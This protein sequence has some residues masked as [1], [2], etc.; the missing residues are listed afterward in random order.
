MNS[1]ALPVSVT[2]RIDSVV[3]SAK[4][5]R[6]RQLLFAPSTGIVVGASTGVPS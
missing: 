5:Q 1:T 6:L 3:D 4:T 2:I